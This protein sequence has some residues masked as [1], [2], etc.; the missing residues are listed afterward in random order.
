MEN[1]TNSEFSEPKNYSG[2]KLFDPKKFFVK[3]WQADIEN[4]KNRQEKSTVV[5]NNYKQEQEKITVLPNNYQQ[6]QE[7]KEIQLYFLKTTKRPVKW[8]ER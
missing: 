5:L 2:K 8:D 7:N 3:K 4:I 1:V 6:E